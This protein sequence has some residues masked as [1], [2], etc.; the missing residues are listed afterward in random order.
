MFLD[1][2]K[3]PVSGDNVIFRR[4][5]LTL[6]R[7]EPTPGSDHRNK[8]RCLLASNLSE[9]DSGFQRYCRG[10]IMKLSGGYRVDS[11]KVTN[12]SGCSIHHQKSD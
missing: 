4:L 11:P 10:N 2:K 8:G 5:L 7:L 1:T 12:H 6:F 9:R 3:L